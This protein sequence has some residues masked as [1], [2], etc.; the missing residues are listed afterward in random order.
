MSPRV[1]V[2]VPAY[3]ASGS[4]AATLRSVLAQS[5]DDW[6][7]VVVDD[8][9]TDDTAA[10]ARGVSPR[11]TVVSAATNRGPAAARNLAIERAGGE[12]LA[13]LDADDLWLGGYLAS[14]VDVY[15]SARRQGTDVGVV[16]CDACLEDAGGR[17]LTGTYRSRVPFPAEVTVETLIE[18]N[19]IFI[20]ALVPAQLVRDLGCFDTRTFGSE[21]HDLWLRIVERGHRVINNPAVLAVYR[22]GETSV[23]SRRS[24]MARTDQTTYRLALERGLL[25][26]SQRRLARRRLRLMEAVEA[27]ERF[28]SGEERRL[29]V[30]ALASLFG[31]LFTFAAFAAAHPARWPRWLRSAL[32]RSAPWRRGVRSGAS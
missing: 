32:S 12:L 14:Q 28:L 5:Y 7:I 31:G 30:R 13:F 15:D 18:G 9:S 8:A 4:I 20:S 26:P 10:V 27:V 23:S 29:S 11:I 19:P 25:S 3:N 16:A 22:M 1:S 17:R 24:A 6:E 21:D 2:I